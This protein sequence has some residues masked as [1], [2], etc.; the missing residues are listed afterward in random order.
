M[1]GSPRYGI[2]R[3]LDCSHE[4]GIARIRKAL[5]DQGFGVLTEIDMAGT[6]KKK[7]DHDMRPYVILG[8]CHPP[9]ARQAVTH[10]PAVGLLLPCNVVVTTDDAGKAV[11][12]A[13]DAEVMFEVVGNPAMNALVAEVKQALQTAIDAA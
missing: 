7:L 2:V 5:A 9:S 10:E 3:T 12:G 6:L 1:L 11:I 8:A 4:D 13:I